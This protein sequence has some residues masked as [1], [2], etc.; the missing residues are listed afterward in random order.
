MSM[1][2]RVYAAAIFVIIGLCCIGVY[3]AISGFMNA[4]PNGLQIGLNLETGTPTAGVTIEIPTETAAPPTNTPLPPTIT[5]EGF[6]PTAI[7][8]ATRGPT[9]DFLPTIETPTVTPTPEATAT[10][11]GCGASF[12]PRLGPPDPR[13]PTGNPCPDNYIWGFVLDT[14]GNGMGGMR[15]ALREING[16]ADKVT[17]KAPPD[18]EGRFDFPASAGTWT[19]QLVDRSENPLSPPIQIQANVPWGGSGNCPTRVDFVQQ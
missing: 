12:C 10:P 19:V 8:A 13:A 9:L 14:G 17:S 6:Q 11:P 5:P 16:G 3:V 4:N 1:Q 7:P 15:I 18:P 2:D